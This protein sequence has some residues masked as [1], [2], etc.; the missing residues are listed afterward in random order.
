MISSSGKLPFHYFS[1]MGGG[2]M[3]ERPSG[4]T[5]KCSSR[6]FVDLSPEQILAM[7]GKDSPQFKKYLQEL[8]EK[9]NVNKSK[10]ERILY[11]VQPDGTVYQLYD[12]DTLKC[13]DKNKIGNYYRLEISGNST[14]IL[15]DYQ[16]TTDQK[17][18]ESWDPAY[19]QTAKTIFD[20]NNFQTGDNMELN[21]NFSD[22]QITKCKETG[23]GCTS[24]DMLNN[25]T[26]IGCMNI[27]PNGSIGTGEKSYSMPIQKFLFKNDIPNDTTLF[28]P[29][30][31]DVVYNSWNGS[32]GVTEIQIEDCSKMSGFTQNGTSAPMNTSLDNDNIVKPDNASIGDS[33]RCITG[34]GGSDN[35]S[36]MSSK[37]T[38]MSKKLGPKGSSTDNKN[39]FTIYRVMEDYSLR[40]YPDDDP[41]VPLS[42]NDKYMNI[43]Q[44]YK[45]CS[46]F[47]FGPVLTIN[48][49]N[50]D[51]SIEYIKGVINNIARYLEI[52]NLTNLNDISGNMVTLKNDLDMMLLG[53]LKTGIWGKNDL[54]L[55]NQD[56][57]KVKDDLNRKNTAYATNLSKEIS[58]EI[59][60]MIFNV[61]DNMWK[62]FKN[63]KIYNYRD[64]KGLIMREDTW[65]VHMGPDEG[66]HTWTW[67]Y[68]E[69]AD[70]LKDTY[71]KNDDIKAGYK[72]GR[73]RNDQTGTC[74]SDGDNGDDHWASMTVCTDPK[75][76]MHLFSGGPNTEATGDDVNT[77]KNSIILQSD[78]GRCIN[79]GSRGTKGNFKGCSFD[80]TDQLL[81]AI[82]K[83]TI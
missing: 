16:F 59:Q 40:G 66:N 54:M 43:S 14:G 68:D 47:T 2:K 64:G 12:G 81:L 31:T 27:N 45:D 56:I 53:K 42:W 75:T 55:V 4:T 34:E 30:Q 13:N 62:P 26:I 38:D 72:S 8:E 78:S 28:H 1:I 51:N 50:P 10:D 3:C 65:I 74:L 25:N 71:N 73:L 41:V 36:K 61:Q 5:F 23:I 79:F 63:A 52:Y 60:S 76:R 80:Y 82:P 15:H 17:I 67:I 21:T 57:A 48:T 29:I 24:S 69:D 18:I 20:C 46:Q 33:I 70:F 11:Y 6:N 58:D 7:Y 83:T 37:A 77:L 49:N 22:E 19:T 44:T 35:M 32:K 9:E 39:S